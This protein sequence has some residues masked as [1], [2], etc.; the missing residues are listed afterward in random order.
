MSE[1]CDEYVGNVCTGFGDD[2]PTCMRCKHPYSAHTDYEAI[3]LLTRIL[4]TTDE[5]AGE[6]SPPGPHT[7][8]GPPDGRCI[9]CQVFQATHP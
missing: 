4:N 2:D 7:F 9:L 3:D 5:A 6:Y 8:T 1:I